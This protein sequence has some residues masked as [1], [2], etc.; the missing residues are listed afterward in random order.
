MLKKETL[1]IIKEYK[2]LHCNSS[3]YSI[4]I[5]L[6]VHEMSF[7]NKWGRKR[8]EQGVRSYQII[9]TRVIY[10]NFF[11]NNDIKNERNINKFVL[12]SFSFNNKNKNIIFVPR[13]KSF[14]KHFSFCPFISHFLNFSYF[15]FSSI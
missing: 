9:Y 7:H 14:N 4:I 3:I 13:L 6:F 1:S 5:C 15:H 10:S 2:N 12:N 11:G 8:A